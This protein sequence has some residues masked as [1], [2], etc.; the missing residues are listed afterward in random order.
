VALAPIVNGYFVVPTESASPRY[1]ES[2]G[3]RDVTSLQ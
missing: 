3:L 2:D 1:F